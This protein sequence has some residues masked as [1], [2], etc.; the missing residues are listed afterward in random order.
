M[1][2]VTRAKTSAKKGKEEGEQK[3]RRSASKIS[4]MMHIENRFQ[5]C[6]VS[7]NSTWC[8]RTEGKMKECHGGGTKYEKLKNAM[9]W[10]P[11]TCTATVNNMYSIL[12]G[13]KCVCHVL[14]QESCLNACMHWLHN[15]GQHNASDSNVFKCATKER[16]RHL[17]SP[18]MSCSHSTRTD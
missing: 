5:V 7:V 3:K 4:M 13:K 10:W 2:H 18:L 14:C 15:R 6:D 8:W 16:G 12:R 1:K 9:W 17:L 11:K